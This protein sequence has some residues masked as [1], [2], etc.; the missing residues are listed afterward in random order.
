MNN[1]NVDIIEGYLDGTLPEAERQ[2]LEERLVNE[3][4]LQAALQWH[5]DLRKIAIAAEEVRLIQFLKNTSSQPAKIV[6][7]SYKV[8]SLAA[9]ILLLILAGIWWLI[10]RPSADL[11]A[12][13][14]QPYPNVSVPL[15]RNEL[16]E[17][18][19]IR[20]FQTYERADYPLAAAQ[21][22]SLLQ[23]DSNSDYRFYLAMS[24]LSTEQY[25]SAIENLQMV[26]QNE[27]SNLQE[28]SI[29]YLALAYWKVG[30]VNQSTILLKNIAA[31]DQ[32]PF[33]QKAQGVLKE[34]GLE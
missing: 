32:H 15:E 4:D 30:D 18:L 27:N 16:R 25:L 29:W 3:A 6:K 26:Q 2:Q 24:Q 23:T 20:A 7:L 28:Y 5:R 14:F 33:G 13:Q 12:D 21:F 10:P 19:K 34:Y 22:D 11:F 8:Y 1:Q 9:V 17:D 31:D